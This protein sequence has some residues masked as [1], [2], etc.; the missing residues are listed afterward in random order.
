MKHR[1]Y[2]AGVAERTH[3]HIS[4]KHTT[5]TSSTDRSDSC[6][7]QDMKALT[8]GTQLAGFCTNSFVS[9]TLF[10]TKLGFTPPKIKKFGE[11]KS[12]ERFAE[13]HT[14]CS[15]VTGTFRKVIWPSSSFPRSAGPRTSHTVQPLLDDKQGWLPR[16]ANREAARKL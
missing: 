6:T 7:G 4:L 8:G 3:W 2:G 12:P 14:I 9:Y 16:R 15:L 1:R 13:L 5:E 10:S 11:V